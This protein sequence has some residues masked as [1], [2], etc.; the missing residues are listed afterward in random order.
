MEA[1]V[2][3]TGAFAPPGGVDCAG[4]LVLTLK[5]GEEEAGTYTVDWN[6]KDDLG[7]DLANGIYFYRL[8]AGEFDQTRKMILLR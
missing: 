6:R 3:A 5:N 8:T 4:R 2:A 1:I 7:R